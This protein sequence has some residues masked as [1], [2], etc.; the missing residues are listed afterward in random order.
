MD[1]LT[2]VHVVHVR[3]V[4]TFAELGRLPHLKTLV[5]HHAAINVPCD[6]LEGMDQPGFQGLRRLMLVDGSWGQTYLANI[7]PHL[8]DKLQAF[9]VSRLHR[10]V[11]TFWH[12][13][14]C[15]RQLRTLILQR[16]EDGVELDHYAGDGASSPVNTDATVPRISWWQALA[17]LRQLRTLAIKTMNKTAAACLLAT[18]AALPRL[19]ELAVGQTPLEVDPAV[20]ILLQACGSASLKV[21]VNGFDRCWRRE[22]TPGAQS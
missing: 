10:Y 6:L 5:I 7:A 4:S 22:C 13:L 2:H 12:H 17:E 9:G 1:Q 21:T 16:V 11:W 18:L 3:G 14:S 8:R 15:C 19:Q 20:C